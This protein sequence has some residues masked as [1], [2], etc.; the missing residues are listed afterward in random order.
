MERRR[1]RRAPFVAAVKHK[2]GGDV[3]LALAQNLGPTG[4]ELKRPAGR[5]YMP[6][7]PVTLA[8]ELPDGGD[9]VRV[10]GAIVFERAASN[11][12]QTT[13]VRF[14]AMTPLDHA[15]IIRALRYL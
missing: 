4:I 11:G 10:Q 8:F 7:T 9:V 5:A 15:R 12:Y 6:R 1:G 13:G 2:V 3:Q 14:L